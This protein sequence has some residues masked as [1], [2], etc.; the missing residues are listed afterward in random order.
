MTYLEAIRK[1]QE[2]LLDEDPRVFIYGQD[3]GAFGGAFKA[4][5][6]LA[7]K[8]PDRVL[9]APISEDAMVGAAVG[10]ALGGMRPVVEMQFADFATVAVNQIV[11]QAGTVYYRTGRSVP[12]VIRMPY[13]GTRGGGPFHSQCN[14]ALFAHYPGLIV[15]HPASV[16]DAY[17]LLRQAVE[18]ED[19]V[20]FFEH[21]FLYHHLRGEIG[22]ASEQPAWHRAQ[23]LRQGTDVTVA[24]YGAM[25]L[26]V[27]KVAESLEAE[28]FGV[29]VLDLR[30]IKPLDVESVVAS[31]RRTGRFCAVGEAFPWGGV[32][33]ELVAAVASSGFS[34]LDA[35]PIRINAMDTPVPWHPDLWHRHRPEAG[36]IADALRN[37]LRF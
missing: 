19:P 1:A 15:M 25:V 26:E 29:E 34:C 13:G 8:H 14:E 18:L 12:M 36:R 23:V 2:D 4:T 35:P 33:A 11:N 21:K 24:T 28:G 30:V 10:A 6:G 3:V 20:L 7:E 37:L 16:S 27:L 5:R 32:T 9:D 31:V 22:K 17:H